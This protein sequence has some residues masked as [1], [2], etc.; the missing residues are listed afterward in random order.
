MP[1]DKMCFCQHPWRIIEGLAAVII[2]SMFVACGESP[3]PCAL[4]PSCASATATVR[5]TTTAAPITPTPSRVP[6]LPS[7]V[8]PNW[9]LALDDAFTDN[10]SISEW[11]IGVDDPGTNRE[12]TSEGYRL[13]APKNG[14]I[15][16]LANN[17]RDT[18]TDF[19]F[20]AT[21][22]IESGTT[23]NGGGAG[24]VFRSDEDGSDYSFTM[25]VNGDWSVERYQN[26][27]PPHLKSLKDG[28]AVRPLFATGFGQKNILTV[29]V[30][31]NTI[32]VFVNN[33]ALATMSDSLIHQGQLGL[34]VNGGQATAAV[35]VFTDARVWI[36]P[37]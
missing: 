37:A 25:D 33:N 27:S 36:P 12:F 16:G 10:N 13:T 22:T 15:E 23:D 5:P 9:R 24:L 2:L 19:F 18:F 17:P 1:S 21:M 32:T 8:P 29:E 3:A 26:T 30:V 28:T 20:Q 6:V 11:D 14:V 34:T 35:A 31:G 4:A 7:P